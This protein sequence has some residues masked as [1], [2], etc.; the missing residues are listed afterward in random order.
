MSARKDF[1]QFTI[2]EVLEKIISKNKLGSKLTEAWL[3][4]NWQKIMGATIASHTNRIYVSGKILNVYLNSPVL[5]NELSY[6]RK[7]V[8]TLVNTEAGYDAIEDVVIR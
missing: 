4:E 3:R 7:K 6:N 5:K 2:A 1:H 8:I